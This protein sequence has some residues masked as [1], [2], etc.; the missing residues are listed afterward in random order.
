MVRKKLWKIALL[1]VSSEYA[2]S[3]AILLLLTL[4]A[5]VLLSIGTFTLMKHHRQQLQK[6][7][8]YR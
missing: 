6:I 5:L 1:C 2:L 7:R 3:A 4:S 8:E